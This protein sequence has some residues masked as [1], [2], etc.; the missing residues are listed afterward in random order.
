[1]HMAEHGLSAFDAAAI[2][3][4]LAATLGYVN[5]RFLRLPSSVGLTVMGAIA[6]LIIVA[7][8]AIFPALG[9]TQGV[10]RFLLGIDFHTTLMDGMLSFLLF[11]GALHVDWVAMQRGR[12][13]IALL[14]TLGVLLSTL[15]VG[16]GLFVIAQLAAL[17]IPLIWCMVFGA[18]I[19]PTDPVAVMAI[20]KRT[21]VP[22]DLQA[23]VAGESLFNDG[24]GVVI[25]SILL[26][27]AVGSEQFALPS[28][29]TA[30][31]QE[32]VGGAAL[33]AAVGYIAFRAMR[34]IDEY[35]VE[36]MISLAVVMAGYSV[37]H[38]LHVSGP[39]AMAVAGLLIGN[40]GVAHAMSD[41]TQDY[42]IKFWA[43]VDEILNAV[44]FLL[45]GME[46]II[47]VGQP[48]LLV[49]GLAAIPL[50]LAARALSVIGPLVLVRR[51][52]TLGRQTVPTLVWG[53]LRGG[54]SIALALSLPAGPVRDAII[55]IT[56]VVVL[57]AVII[58]GATIGGLISRL[59]DTAAPRD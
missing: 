42:L 30:F 20:M 24:V 50:V 39:V 33:G 14:A 10:E 58:Q 5:H 6:S 26:T 3:I 48:H 23:M 52:V 8:G 15:I 32:A 16:A 21:A 19:S 11:A 31:V 4:L 53:G 46:V 13:A 54:I 34:S 12:W 44:L 22:D 9:L 29:V 35:N 49:L 18:L 41:E 40:A 7:V 17:P 45:I 56:F 47:I 38:W 1:M 59:D 37:A 36:V 51:T 43:L 2:L 25:F 57:F 55:A 27:V 28:A